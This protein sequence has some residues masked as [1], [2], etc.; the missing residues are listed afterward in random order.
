MNKQLGRQR[1]HHQRHQRLQQHLAERRDLGARIQLEGLWQLDLVAVGLFQLAP[2]IDQIHQHE[3]R[4]Q[5]GFTGEGHH[6]EG[7]RHQ[8]DADEPGLIT[9]YLALHLAIDGPVLPAHAQQQGH[10][11]GGITYGG[12]H[13]RAAEGGTYAYLLLSGGIPHQQGGQ[14][15]DAFG[16]GRAEGRQQGAGGALG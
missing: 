7:H 2:H 1:H 11:D 4:S 10:A 15:D 8:E 13:Q 14:G 16:Q 9:A 3:Q 5:P 12:Q 6:A